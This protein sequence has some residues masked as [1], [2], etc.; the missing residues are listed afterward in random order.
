LRLSAATSRE[1]KLNA[2]REFERY[3]FVRARFSRGVFSIAVAKV[4]P[5]TV[6]ERA[7]IFF[8]SSSF[9]LNC[10]FGAQLT[11]LFPGKKRR[12]RSLLEA[13]GFQSSFFLSIQTHIFFT[14]A[15]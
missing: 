9:S 2:D 1:K 15:D 13:F 10:G 11:G 8:F 6:S 7:P 14:N 5:E 3:G 4:F 12:R